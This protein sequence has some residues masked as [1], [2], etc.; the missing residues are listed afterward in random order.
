MNKGGGGMG[1][2]IIRSTKTLRQVALPSASWERDCEAGVM[3]K[4]TFLVYL[5]RH[6]SVRKGKNCTAGDSTVL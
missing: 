2:V 6:C 5:F 1:E 4:S 3:F